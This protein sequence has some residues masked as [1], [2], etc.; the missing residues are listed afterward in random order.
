MIGVLGHD[1]A[2]LRLYW[3]WDNLGRE[4]LEG[5]NFNDVDDNGG[6]GDYDNP[7]YG[8]SNDDIDFWL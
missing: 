8:N 3:D 5:E 2:L 1:I 4:I 6:G 7:D